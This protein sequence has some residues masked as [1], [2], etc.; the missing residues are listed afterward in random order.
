MLSHVYIKKD[1]THNNL[2]IK[3]F[4]KNSTRDKITSG[5]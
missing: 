4:D 1:I 3:R 5:N 2:I